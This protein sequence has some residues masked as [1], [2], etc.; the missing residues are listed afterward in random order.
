VK[1]IDAF[2]FNMTQKFTPNNYERAIYTH[3]TGFSFGQY[4]MLG[5]TA[6][7]LN[8]DNVGKCRTGKDTGYD[9]EGDV[10]PLTNEKNT[11]TCAQLEVFKVIYN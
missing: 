3:K 10:S 5:L 7:L 8:A 9:I 4:D 6:L 2:V 1:D 11:F